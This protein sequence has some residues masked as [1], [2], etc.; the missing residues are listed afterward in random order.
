M[1]TTTIK[2]NRWQNHGKDR[3]YVSGLEGLRIGKCFVEDRGGAIK[4]CFDRDAA[5]AHRSSVPL[6]ENDVYEAIEAVAGRDLLDTTYTTFV[7][8]LEGGA[9]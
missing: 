6:W 7:A 9:A 2:F 5:T 4:V 8:A 3:C 1:T